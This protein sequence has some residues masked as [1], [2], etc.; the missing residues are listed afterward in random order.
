MLRGGPASRQ[1][2][3]HR[4]PGHNADR[5]Y[6][7]SDGH[8]YSHRHSRPIS[9]ICPYA[10]TDAAPYAHTHTIANVDAHAC[11]IANPAPNANTDTNTNPY[12]HS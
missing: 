11:T 3:S 8:A 7:G 1:H 2:S 12:A 6:S 5:N 10:G 9:N 4:S